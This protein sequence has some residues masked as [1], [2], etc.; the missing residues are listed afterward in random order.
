MFNKFSLS[1]EPMSPIYG[2]FEMQVVALDFQTT[3]FQIIKEIETVTVTR[4][5]YPEY[6]INGA[7]WENQEVVGVQTP[8]DPNEIILKNAFETQGANIIRIQ[9]KACNQTELADGL[10]C[11]NQ[12]ET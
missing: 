12:Y 1:W 3:K 8:A 6:F 5:N 10:L 11:A 2:K 4:E 7:P 9:L